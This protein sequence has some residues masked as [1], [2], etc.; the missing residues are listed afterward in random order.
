MIASIFLIPAVCQLGTNTSSLSSHLYDCEVPAESVSGAKRKW[1][2]FDPL[3]RVP[4]HQKMLIQISFCYDLQYEKFLSFLSTAVL[5]YQL[6][7][8]D[9]V[10]MSCSDFTLLLRVAKLVCR[11]Q[12]R[13][14]AWWVC[15]PL[16]PGQTTGTAVTLSSAMG[17]P[18]Q[19]LLPRLGSP[20]PFQ[21]PQTHEELHCWQCWPLLGS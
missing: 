21:W 4:Y 18:A 14:S 8:W 16:A 5:L 13:V 7:S 10:K 2:D 6:L 17:L 9:C 11:L 1:R 15:A 12:H 19:L 20:L 3:N